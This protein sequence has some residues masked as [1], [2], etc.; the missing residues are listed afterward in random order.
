[1]SYLKMIPFTSYKKDFYLQKLCNIGAEE[2]GYQ[3][4]HPWFAGFLKRQV[5]GNLR[6][7]R[8]WWKSS[9]KKV[10]RSKLFPNV[11]QV[12]KAEMRMLAQPNA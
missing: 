2:K 3:L 9:H 1:M 12:E 4:Q 11:C 7:G 8:F 10:E 6:E 5:S